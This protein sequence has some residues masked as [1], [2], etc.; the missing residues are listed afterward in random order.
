MQAFK[1]VLQIIFY[2]I[3][4]PLGLFIFALI[5]FLIVAD[6][7]EKLGSLGSGSSFGGPGGFGP[8]GGGFPSQE[9]MQQFQ[10][11]GGAPGGGQFGPHGQ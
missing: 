1:S 2:L 10:Q 3:W 7:L 6:P 8:P 11:Q 5:I 9:Q 4:V